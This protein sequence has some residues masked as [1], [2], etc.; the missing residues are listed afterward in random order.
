NAHCGIDDDHIPD[1]RWIVS[2]KLVHS[3]VEMS[4]GLGEIRQIDTF[5]SLQMEEDTLRSRP[6]ERFQTR[7]TSE[8]SLA[9]LLRRLHMETSTLRCEGL[10][11]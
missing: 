4:G 2:Q 8:R 10:R 5:L 3:S 11:R 6:R 9:I 1:S 7:T